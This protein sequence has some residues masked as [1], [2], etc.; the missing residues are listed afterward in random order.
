MKARRSALEGTEGVLGLGDL[1]KE[2]IRASAHLIP[3][4]G[5]QDRRLLPAGY[6]AASELP[7]FLPLGFVL[8]LAPVVFA[9]AA[10][11]FDAALR[12][13]ARRF[14]TSPRAVRASSK[15]TASPSVMAS[16]FVSRGTVAL[17]PL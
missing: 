15:L 14:G 10:V 17:T 1:A 9:A 8:G 13:G 6:S 4:K 5:K 3:Q 2:I 12:V 7:F 16:G 11:R